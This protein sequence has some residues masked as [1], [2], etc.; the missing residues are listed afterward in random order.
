MDDNSQSFNLGA[1]LTGITTI[2]SGESAIFI[3]SG[4]LAGAR[5]AFTN[6]WFGGN[7]PAGLQIG[8]Y[9]GSGVGLSTSPSDQVNLYSSTGALQT[10]VAFG[11]SPDAAPFATFENS[12]AITSIN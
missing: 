4:D 8:V 7:A 12:T 2:H 10:S 11:S 1:A 6:L 5:S 9:S 3:E